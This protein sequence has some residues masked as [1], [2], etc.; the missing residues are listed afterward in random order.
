MVGK[1]AVSYPDKVCGLSAATELMDILSFRVINVFKTMIQDEEI[2]DKDATE[3]LDRIQQ[4]ALTAQNVMPGAK[5][6]LVSI[7]R[8]VC[9]CPQHNPSPF[10]ILLQRTGAD[11]TVRMPNMPN[12]PPPAIIPKQKKLKLLDVDPLELARQLTIME[13]KL[14]CKIRSMECLQR[15]KEQEGEK[16]DNVKN[17]ISTSN[18]VTS[19]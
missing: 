12:L 10:L 4:F 6:L 5:Q 19:H 15:A 8:A 2:L 17:I 7:E 14:Y 1:E 13:S 16:I 18:K 11:A 3:I 9:R